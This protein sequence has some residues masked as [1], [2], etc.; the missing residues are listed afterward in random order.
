MI[1]K[2]GKPNASL[3]ECRKNCR[4][5]HEPEKVCY[6]WNC[7]REKCRKA[8]LY[9]EK[10]RLKEGIEL[11]AKQGDIWFLTIYFSSRKIDSSVTF[12]PSYVEFQKACTKLLQT[13][14]RWAKK[15]SVKLSYARVNGIKSDRSF[16]PFKLHAHI[17]TSWMPETTPNPTTQYPFR[18]SCEP[19][20]DYAAKYGLTIWIEKVQ[21]PDAV[22]KYC[23]KN[24]EHLMDTCLPRGFNRYSY[25]RNW[26]KLEYQKKRQEKNRLKREA[27]YHSYSATLVTN[28]DLEELVSELPI[29]DKPN[30][31]ANYQQLRKQKYLK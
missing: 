28:K 18:H 19:V 11:I 10:L 25:S 21:N 1:R 4:F 7:R 13:V 30:T 2:Y 27:M 8:K 3:D 6:R 9:I 17:V 22:A 5:E 15:E 16:S 23:A 12:N 24:L 31:D 20:E 29:G 14:S 26:F